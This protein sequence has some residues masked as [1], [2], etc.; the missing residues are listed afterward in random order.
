[1]LHRFGSWCSNIQV[2]TLHHWVHIGHHWVQVGLHCDTFGLQV[3]HSCSHIQVRLH[4]KQVRLQLG[5]EIEMFMQVRHSLIRDVMHGAVL[6]GLE[7]VH[8]GICIEHSTIQV[9]FGLHDVC[10]EDVLGLDVC[11]EDVLGGQQFGLKMFEMFMSMMFGL[12]MFVSNGL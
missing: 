9:K 7:G 4:I 6:V 8:S 3:V 11:L 10:L 12:M 2:H 5:L 1:M